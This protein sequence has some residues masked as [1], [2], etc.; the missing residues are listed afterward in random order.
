MD[1]FIATG[2][3]GI[4][5]SVGDSPQRIEDM[6]EDTSMMTEIQYKKDLGSFLQTVV[7]EDDM[8]LGR[9]TPEDE[10]SVHVETSHAHNYIHFEYPG[11]TGFSLRMPV[12]VK[13]STKYPHGV[14]EA[15]YYDEKVL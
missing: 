13:D 5:I 6:Y 12:L 3:D 10:V 11:G 2:N 1:K 7:N 14:T 8:E 4:E 9:I 15:N